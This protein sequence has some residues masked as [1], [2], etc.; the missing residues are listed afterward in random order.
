MSLPINPRTEVWNNCIFVCHFHVIKILKRAALGRRRSRGQHKRCNFCRIFPIC[1]TRVVSYFQEISELIK[2]ERIAYILKHSPDGIDCSIGTKLY[3][4]KYSAEPY[5]K[6]AEWYYFGQT[7]GTR[8]GDLCGSAYN[9]KAGKYELI[10]LPRNFV[11]DDPNGFSTIANVNAGTIIVPHITKFN[12]Y[13]T[14]IKYTIICRAL[15]L[16]SVPM[17]PWPFNSLTLFI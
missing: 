17:C 5:P 1:E 16:T 7:V 12:Q 8:N 15:L 9:N 2:R 4:K 10:V 6:F 11:H 14:Y 13:F 3:N